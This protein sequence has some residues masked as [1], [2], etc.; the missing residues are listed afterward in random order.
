MVHRASGAV[1][2]LVAVIALVGHARAQV[3]GLGQAEF[4]LTPKALAKSVEE[5]ESRIA[6]CMRDQGFKYLAVDYSTVRKGM[7][8]IMWLPGLSEARFIEKHGFGIA[9]LYSGQPPQLVEGYSPGKV[10]LGEKNVAIFRNLSPADQVAYNRAL[11]GGNIDATFAV[12]ID[13]EDFSRC[14][15]CT[16][17]A[18]EQVF[19]PEQ[20]KVTYYNPKD[21][22][23]EKD[24]RMKA[25]LREYAD[26]MRKAG[27]GYSHPEEVEKDIR[28]R[29]Q[30]ITRGETI[31]VEKMSP[32][33]REAL[34]ELQDYERRV[35]VLNYRL[36]ELI[37]EEVESQIEDELFARTVQ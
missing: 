37:L 9:T 6:A 27:F 5:I 16:R 12:G 15:G 34:A 32:R 20:L 25:A 3:E 2:A 28:A 17:K 7:Q 22:L 29:L 33:Q 21:V 30:A 19:Q 18:I 1:V 24:P 31:P 23:I 26:E 13:T 4:G 36:E 8:A 14:G 10:G 11:F 35:A